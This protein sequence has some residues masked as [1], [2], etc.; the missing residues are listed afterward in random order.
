MTA[1]TAVGRFGKG[2]LRTRRGR[3]GLLLVLA[4]VIASVAVWRAPDLHHVSRAFTAVKWQWVMASFALNLVSTWL[5]ARAWQ[6][7]LEQAI[8]TPHPRHRHV[9]SAFAVGLLGNAVLPG[10]VGE[11]ARV[12]V[13][14]R[15]L[16]RPT[17]DWPAVA[18]SV[19]VH[20]LFDVLPTAGLAAYVIVVAK[21]PRWAVP[22]VEIV[23]AVGGVLLIGA[24]VLARRSARSLAGQR[25][26]VRWLEM[27][28]RG[29][30]VLRRPRATLVA[31]LLQAGAWTA[32]LFA[33]WL[34]FRAFG[35]DHQPIAAA[36]LVLLVVNV[37]LAFPLWPGAVGLFQ[38]AVALA[39]LPYGIAYHHGFGYGVG[40]QVIET[41]VGVGL[42]V[43][44]LAREGLSFAAL[45]QMP[46]VTEDVD[47]ADDE[48][49]EEE[50]AAVEPR[51][52]PARRF[53]PPA[54]AGCRGARELVRCSR[55]SSV[56]SR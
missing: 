15:H 20:R 30:S 37:A 22:G 5:R 39:L 38:A 35:I 19:V 32:Q 3:L 13:V 18:G 42:G 33:V 55:E 40:L 2:V 43:L 49:R 17:R 41:V 54:D 11:F 16:E 52:A 51:L 1:V 24:L 29:L 28:R 9:F 6:V 10:R 47:D 25:R 23:L 12:A 27:T 31:T 53:R 45:R 48:A 46:R 26:I 56:R 14:A 44:F 21:L 50:A 36:A 8:P 34:A 4:G 7:A